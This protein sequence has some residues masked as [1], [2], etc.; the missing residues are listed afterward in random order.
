LICRFDYGHGFLKDNL[1]GNC[2]CGTAMCV[3]PD[4][5]RQIAEEEQEEGEECK[6]TE[7]VKKERRR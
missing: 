7:K 5:K 4:I 3:G 1:K 2:N 6:E